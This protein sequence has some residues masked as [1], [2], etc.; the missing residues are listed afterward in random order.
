M[1]RIAR[2]LLLFCVPFLI[3][4]CSKDSPEDENYCLDPS[5]KVPLEVVVNVDESFKDY[6]TVDSFGY[7]TRSDDIEPYLRYYVAAY[8]MTSGLPTV[9]SSGTDRKLSM[10][11]HPGRYTIV[12]W[13]MYEA[14]NKIHG[15]NFYDDDLSELLLKNKYNYSG[16]DPYKIAFRTAEAKNIAH[17]TRSI[18]INARPAMARYRII[19]TD[20]AS[21]EPVK[22]LIRYTSPLPAAIHAKTGE[23]NWWW[24][25]INFTSTISNIIDVG[26]KLATDLVLSQDGKQTSVTATVEIF[27]KDD[28]IRARKKNVRIP[29]T[30]GGVTTV[31]GRF[32]SVLEL[33]EDASSGSGISI[34][35]EWDATFEIEL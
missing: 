18:D 19:A 30:N 32:Y 4:S 17:N 9:V 13:V 24:T 7:K 3:G 33:D 10:H 35:T 22:V 23:I 14:D 21:F 34:K 31:T 12:G 15:Y 27:D 16:G 29:L 5:Y 20:T 11:I 28:R 2:Q 1:K 8:P 26:E 25:D 6:L